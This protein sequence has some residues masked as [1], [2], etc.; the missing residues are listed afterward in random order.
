[1]KCDVWSL[2]IMFYYILFGILPW[3]DTHSIMQ[4]LNAINTKEI[5]FPQTNPISE[6]MKDIIKVIVE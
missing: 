4:L 6:S 3:K 1:M 5:Q 2:G